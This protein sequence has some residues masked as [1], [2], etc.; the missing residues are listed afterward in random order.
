MKIGLLVVATGKYIDFVQPLWDSVKKYF[1]ANSK[2]KISMFVFTDAK[3][4]PEGTIKCFQKH[5]KFPA[6]TLFRYKWFLKQEKRLAKMDH[7]FYCDVDMKFV[8]FVGKETLSKLTATLHPGFY[9]RSRREFSYETRKESTAFISP[10]EGKNY[11]CG[12]F[13]G[14]ET[15]EYLKMAK[16][17]AK[18][19][20]EDL[21]KGIVAV[22]HDESHLNRYLIDNPPSRILSPSYCYPEELALPFKPKLLALKKDHSKWR[23]SGIE[24]V[25]HESFE[26]FKREMFFLTQ[27][28]R[29]SNSKERE[30]FLDIVTIAFN[31][32]SVIEQQIFFLQKNLKDPFVY[33]VADNSS[34]PKAQK[35]IAHVCRDN[36][37]NYL[38][39]A[40][41]VI[42]YGPSESHGRAITWVF[43]NFIKKRNAK[44][45][46]FVDH[47]IFPTQGTSI[48]SFLDGQPVY[49]LLQERKPKWYLWAGFCF[50]NADQTL[51]KI[52]NFRPGNGLD[53]GGK[54]WGSLYSKIDKNALKFPP[55]SYLKIVGGKLK[56]IGKKDG[57]QDLVR[58]DE[59]VEKIGDWL[60][61]FNASNWR[62]NYNKRENDIKSMIQN[63]KS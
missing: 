29:K 20:D 37:I 24:R 25:S 28:I 14:G 13:N 35:E 59:L 57:T 44:Y 60:H 31:N 32:S 53:T 42:K 1:F 18:N 61:L 48:I 55:Q 15:K 16:V 27:K 49:G 54:N 40:Q 43:E 50:F 30:N 46:G 7:L 4:V 26:F 10:L 36:R 17:I 58:K 45:F 22:W 8:D 51:N 33:T 23:Y 47:D 9:N 52:G 62:G 3:Q 56:S 41:S 12:G 19:V 5:E 21:K 34:D 38:R 2:Y 39:V 63:E 6:P 11:Y